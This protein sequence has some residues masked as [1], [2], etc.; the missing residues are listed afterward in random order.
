MTR[1]DGL[2]RVVRTVV[3]YV[4]VHSWAFLCRVDEGKKRLASWEVLHMLEEGVRG[5]N[6]D[7]GIGS[8][9]VSRGG[10]CR[11]DYLTPRDENS[12]WCTRGSWWPEM[13]RIKDCSAGLGCFEERVGTIGHEQDIQRPVISTSHEK[14]ALR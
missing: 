12:W 10:Q 8:C 6:Q 5:L 9:L 4:F 11:V 14:L 13:T 3:R 7:G 2:G 1:R